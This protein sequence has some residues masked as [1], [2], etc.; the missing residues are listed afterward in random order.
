MRKAGTLKNMAVHV[1]T[2]RATASTGRSRKNGANGNLSVSCTAATT[3]WFEDTTNSD[4]VSAGEDWNY[5]ITTGTGV[6]TL[7][8]R[9][10]TCEF[11][12]TNGD[13][14]NVCSTTAS[15]VVADATNTNFYINGLMVA[16]ATESQTQT[17]A[18]D[19][20]TCSELTCLITQN[21]VTSAST[22]DFRVDLANSALTVSITG[23]A[24]GVFSDSTHT[25]YP[26]NSKRN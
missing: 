13:G 9:D 12:S 10:I 4:T 1:T 8:L 22:L 23:S 16:N 17:K 3:G 18:R 6:D 11:I 20:F 15:I 7:Q 21:D 26:Y 5:S 25:V 19:A 2:A 14:L 24:T